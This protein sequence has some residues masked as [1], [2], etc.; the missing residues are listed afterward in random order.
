MFEHNVH[1]LNKTTI[2][3]HHEEI[4]L[5][6]LKNKTSDTKLKNVVILNNFYF[7]LN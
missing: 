5:V 7:L 3:N 6:K 4:D 1:V 2:A